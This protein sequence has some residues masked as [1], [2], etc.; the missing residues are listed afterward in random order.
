[1]KLY[2]IVIAFF[3]FDKAQSQVDAHYKYWDSGFCSNNIYLKKDGTFYYEQGCEGDSKICKGR[4]SIKDSIL[5]F[6]IDTSKSGK[7]NYGVSFLEKK[8]SDS[9]FI[10]VLDVN[11]LPLPRFRIGL[12]PVPP[13]DKPFMS[14]MVE[15]DVNGE[16]KVAQKEFT[17]FISQH[18]IE[19][20]NDINWIQ[21][22]ESKNFYIMQFNYP[23]T[24]IMYNKIE[25]YKKNLEPLLF[26]NGELYNKKLNMKY[27][28]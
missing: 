20:Q 23:Y 17:H 11:K 4:Y 5:H 14:E 18:E 15:T 3:Y 25:W 10:K 22:K 24:C 6:E 19:L 16:I 2:L 8:P 7:L 12:L 1:M 21:F 28:K 13:K 9:I 27:T 26:Q